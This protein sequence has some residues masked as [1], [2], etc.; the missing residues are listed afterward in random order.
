M[1]DIV[2]KETTTSS[3]DAG[4]QVNR[5]VEV[6]VGNSQTLTRSIYFLFGLIDVLLLFRLVFKITGA[7]P[8]SGFVSFIYALTQ[9]FIAPFAGIFS[10]ATTP[11]AETT[12][13]FE[14]ATLVAI[15]VYA[16]L[17]WGIAKL[18]AILSGRKP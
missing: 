17:A 10:S 14:P 13:V 11:G 8:L 6:K 3:S 2:T 15:I 7:N 16:V 5:P 12:A 9:I 18:V 4:T 1:A